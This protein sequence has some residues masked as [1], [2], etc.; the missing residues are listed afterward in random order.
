[1]VVKGEGLPIKK[2]KLFLIIL[3]TYYQKDILIPLGI[4]FCLLINTVILSI[5]PHTHV[6]IKTPNKAV[7]HLFSY[8]TLYH[9]FVLFCLL[10]LFKF[11]KT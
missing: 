2:K 4:Y 5:T 11:E 9:M 6:C 3:I 7:N 10:I 1:M 8:V